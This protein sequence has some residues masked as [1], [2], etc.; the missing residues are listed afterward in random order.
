MRACENALP[1]AGLA[2]ARPYVAKVLRWFVKS[3]E[4]SDAACNIRAEQLFQKMIEAFLRRRNRPIAP[5][6]LIETLFSS[7]V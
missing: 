2:G 5:S 6:R 7:L 1:V 3:P 4:A